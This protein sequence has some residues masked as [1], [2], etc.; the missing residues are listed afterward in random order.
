MADEG[1]ARS[2]KAP[3]EIF[4]L[5]FVLGIV[6]ANAER[7]AHAEGFVLVLMSADNM[8]NLMHQVA[9]LAR[10]AVVRI[11]NDDS[12]G[13]DKDGD[14]RKRPIGIFADQRDGFLRDTRN[15]V[16]GQNQYSE[17]AC[18]RPRRQG[19]AIPQAKPGAESQGKSL[20][21]RF[22]PPPHR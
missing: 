9:F 13:G 4:C 8:G 22:E 14:C 2:L 16:G 11:V 5:V 7:L 3:A 20:G 12:A 1:L 19:V 15:D 6:D 17:V 10:G 18:Q 21:F